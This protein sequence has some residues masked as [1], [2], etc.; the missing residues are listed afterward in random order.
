MRQW[1][2]AYLFHCTDI[3]NAV[4]ILR[5]G[6]ILSRSQAINTNQLAL[7]IASPE[8]IEHTDPQWQ[9]YVRMYFRPRTPTQYRNEGFRPLSQRA[10]GS[11]CPVPVYFIFDSLT[12]LSWSNCLFSDGNLGTTGTTAEGGIAFLKQIPFDKVYHVGPFSRSDTNNIVYH[13]NAE[14]LVPERM[15]LDSLR[16]IG[17]RSPAEYETLLYLLPP[18][19]LSRWVGKIGVG[20]RLFNREWTFVE[21]VEMSGERLIFRLNRS[22]RTPGPFDVRLELE[23]SNY[24]H[25]SEY[26]CNGALN[27]PLS[28]LRDPNGYTIRLFLD[29]QLAYANRYQGDDLPF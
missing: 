26:Q 13:R 6:E 24:W 3:S 16:Y 7:D 2:P 22:T 28:N 12:I 27:L 23:E 1:W 11:N 5:Q 18:D 20:S 8:I 19:T 4:N 9:D 25:N 21:R 17:C 14:V 15:G 29:D 10:L